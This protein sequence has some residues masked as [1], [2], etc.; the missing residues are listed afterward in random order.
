MIQRMAKA[1]EDTRLLEEVDE[2][3]AGFR[4]RLETQGDALTPLASSRL[5]LAD[6][7]DTYI[8]RV[9]VMVVMMMVMMTIN[10]TVLM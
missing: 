5:R 7:L 8:E 3:R 2:G 4:P 9:Q 6:E 1:R 10:N